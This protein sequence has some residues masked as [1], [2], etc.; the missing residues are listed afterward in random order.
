MEWLGILIHNKEIH[1]KGV[2]PELFCEKKYSL[3]ANP[4]SVPYKQ[5]MLLNNFLRSKYE[6][7]TSHLCYMCHGILAGN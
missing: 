5:R 6:Q 1:I 7:D 3:V 4:S 2:P